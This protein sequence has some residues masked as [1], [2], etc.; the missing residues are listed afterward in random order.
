MGSGI[1]SLEYINRMEANVELSVT[2]F[3]DL[4]LGVVVD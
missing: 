2:L 4:P 3:H 1:I